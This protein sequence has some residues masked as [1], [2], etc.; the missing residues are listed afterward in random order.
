MK[1]LKFGGTS[2]ANAKRL[3]LVKDII[4]FSYEENDCLYVVV[5]AFSGVTDMLISMTDIAKENSNYKPLL[6]DFKQKVNDIAEEL[7]SSSMLQSI[8][9]E[10]EENH[11]ILENLLSGVQLIQ[12]ASDRTRDYILSFGE[13]NCA[14][15]FAQYLSESGFNS[16][17][18]DA[19]KYI[20][21]DD[22][23]GSARVNFHETNKIIKEKL[24]KKGKIYVVTGFIGSDLNSGRTTT[25]GRGGSDYSAAIFAAAVDAEVLEIWTDVDGVLT[26]DPRKV[27]NA[28]PIEELSYAEAMEMSHFGA[29]V[30]YSP[31]IRPVREMGIPTKIK[32]TFNPK[33]PGTLI[34]HT[35][36]KKNKIISGL[37]AIENVA[38]VTLEGTG[39][40]GVS[41][42]ASR[43]FKCLA[44]QD[45]NIIMITQ[46][47]S[48]HSITVAIMQEDSLTAEEF[49]NEEF[50]F[51]LNRKLIDPIR[52]NNGNALL[53][54]IGENMKNS[55]GVAGTLFQI[56]GKNGINIEAI[57]QGSSELNISFA[58][59]QKVVVK[60]LN[61][62][63]DAFFLSEYK[64][65]HIY[66]IGIGLI[67]N[68]LLKQIQEN[69]ES[70]KKTTGIN[71][72][73]NGL[74]NSKKMILSEESI[75][76]ETYQET[77][78]ASSDVADIEGFINKMIDHNHA[79]SI[80]LDSTAIV[81]V[82]PH[83]VRIL[84]NNIAISTPN[85]VAFSSTM[86]NYSA[87][88][89]AVQKYKTPFNFETNVGAGLPVIST[90]KGLI[91]SGDQIQKIEAVL[92]G[93]L[94]Y[95]F[96]NFSSDKLFHDVVKEAQKLGY[97]EPDPREDLS[98][99]DV[100]RK[101]L[102]LARESG[103]NME[104]DQID[105]K[106]FLPEGAMEASSVEAFYSLL[107]D[108]N[109]YFKNKI[110]TAEAS[111]L[112]LRFIATLDGEIGKVSLQSVAEENPFYGLSGSDN[113]IA[114]YTTRYNKT[115]LL[116]RGPGAGA[117]VTAAGVL[118]EIINTSKFL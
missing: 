98:G 106:N 91:D 93:S 40:Q 69:S 65:V 16:E 21:T 29:K 43:L 6:K 5:S 39:M 53:A 13:R 99:N 110:E 57:A 41:G 76:I 73:I 88:K 114:F 9:S 96:N 89:E 92:S 35:N 113:M 68:T 102:I 3:V 45:I 59:Q 4:T 75:N 72:C 71:L 115:P 62:I 24:N 12:E 25:L 22:S 31:T 118:A 20:K 44:N 28:Y 61:A 26:S 10:L 32:N 19:R 64:T 103:L 70:I 23:Y 101:L 79:H 77:L 86:D 18:I 8:K 51:E 42:I 84:S 78:R 14:Y 56:L 11:S 83:Y 17:Y 54:V 7:L 15:V 50:A 112:K 67:G 38:L 105:I 107:K 46:A 111:G 116:V 95:I 104:E 90:L 74:S 97:T 100:R 63:H 60:A 117:D 1:V 47:S 48:E 36:T 37:S 66:M 94:S 58:I 34:H 49:L 87:I 81:S 33:H 109:D 27:K 55:P 30:L 85:K 52:V 82:A 80:F 2:V 108:K